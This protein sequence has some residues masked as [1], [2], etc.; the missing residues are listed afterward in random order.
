MASLQTF[1]NSY[2]FVGKKTEIKKQV[3]NAI[4]PAV[5]RHFVEAIKRTLEDWMA[6]NIDEEGNR[7]RGS[8]LSS[9][10]SSSFTVLNNKA[11]DGGLMEVERSFSP[12]SWVNVERLSLEGDNDI[13]MWDAVNWTGDEY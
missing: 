1:R 7:I 13:E 9:S 11:E 12:T 10:S 3:G 5:W 2:Q 6:G 8:S 4:P